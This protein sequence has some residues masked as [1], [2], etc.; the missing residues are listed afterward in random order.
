MSINFNWN[1]NMFSGKQFIIYLFEVEQVMFTWCKLRYYTICFLYSFFQSS[2]S[3]SDFIH[4]QQIVFFEI[5]SKHLPIN[6]NNIKRKLPQIKYS[7]G[8]FRES[9]VLLISTLQK[10]TF[11]FTKKIIINYLKLLP[12]IRNCI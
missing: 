2:K 1:E 3:F 10:N 7:W 9:F 5:L 4:K 11:T 6:K 8:K 12:Y